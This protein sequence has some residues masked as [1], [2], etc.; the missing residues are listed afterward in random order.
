[1]GKSL[2]QVDGYFQSLDC[3]KQG[4]DIK[5]LKYENLPRGL[6]KVCGR[7]NISLGDGSY[8]LLLSRT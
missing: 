5:R 1:M 6:E 3:R 8:V 2:L 4:T 7:H